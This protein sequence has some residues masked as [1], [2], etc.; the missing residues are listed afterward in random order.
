MFKINMNFLNLFSG[1]SL[2]YFTTIHP[3]DR[4]RKDTGSRVC[5]PACEKVF[6]PS[7]IIS[8]GILLHTIVSGYCGD[9]CLETKEEI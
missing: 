8:Y 9:L 6:N 2:L 1:T 4:L 3:L 5:F 7:F